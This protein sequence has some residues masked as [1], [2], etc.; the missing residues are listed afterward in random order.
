[1]RASSKE[2]L[3]MPPLFALLPKLTT[4]PYAKADRC[5]QICTHKSLNFFID[6]QKKQ[7]DDDCA[8]K[9][10]SSSSSSQADIFCNET[11]S[12]ISQSLLSMPN[13]SEDPSPGETG[14]T[15]LPA[16]DGKTVNQ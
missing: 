3:L 12:S 2:A 5:A 7:P 4:T 8:P 6:V 10:S 14:A 13:M 9:A 16:Q 1:M 11:N 15:S